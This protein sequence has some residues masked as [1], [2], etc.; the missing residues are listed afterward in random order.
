MNLK[1]KY[2]SASEWVIE[3]FKQLTFML[4]KGYAVARDQVYMIIEVLQ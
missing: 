1:I 2:I 4:V 3:R